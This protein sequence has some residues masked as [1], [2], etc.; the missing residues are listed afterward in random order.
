VLKPIPSK[1]M[2]TPAIAVYYA[3]MLAASGET[4][5]AK[6]YRD[7]AAAGAGLLPEERQLLSTIR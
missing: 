7:F 1:V 4:D 3:V 2:E 5:Q 6:K